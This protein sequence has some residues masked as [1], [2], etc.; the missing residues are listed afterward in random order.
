MSIQDLSKFEEL[1]A[2]GRL[3]SPKGVAVAILRLAQREDVT[4][5]DLARLVKTDPA[6]AGRLI[7][8]ANSVNVAARRPVVAVN[9]AIMLLGIPAVTQ[10]AL[11][12]SLV[13]SYRTGACQGFDYDGFWSRSLFT[14]IAMQALTARTGTAAPE[15][16][17][18]CGLLSRIG[19]LALATLYPDDYS[20]VLKNAEAASSLDLTE[21]EQHAFAL[22]HR[23]LTAAQLYDWGIPKALVEPVVHHETPDDGEFAEGSR[24]QILTGSLHL[25]A[26]LA[27]MCTAETGVRAAMLMGLRQACERIGIDTDTLHEIADKA[28][29]DWQEWGELLSVPTQKLPPFA[30]IAAGPDRSGASAAVTADS[31]ALEH[32]WLRVLVVDD[33][34]AVL[35]FLQR[36]LQAEGYEVHVA[37]NGRDALELALDVHPQIVIADS[38]MP[39]MDGIALTRALRQSR[40][41]RSMYILVLTGAED[42]AK[43]VEA[44][45]A[46]ADDFVAKPPRP[47]VLEARL[48]AGRRVIQLRRE[49]EEDREEIR[50]VATELAASNRRLRHAAMLDPLTEFPNRRYAIERLDQEWAHASRSSRPLACMVIDVDSFKHVNDSYGHEAGDAVL[51]KTA[52]VLKRSAR[53]HD[54]ICRIGGDE[55]LVICPDTEST[56][57]L[58]AGERLC[59]AVAATSVEYSSHRFNGSVSVGIAARDPDMPDPRAMMR[60]ADQAMYQA[61]HAGRN[62]ARVYRQLDTSPGLHGS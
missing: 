27:E 54:V 31:A 56:A 49:L 21:L 38:V 62:R 50:D 48:R 10:L 5:S 42:E 2:S 57:A 30:Q 61:K 9:E 15:E 60:A 58:Q 13:T 6:F 25:A 29:A 3:P 53:A 45:D 46:G 39:E 43:L 59:R 11:G 22:D 12:F 24:A 20:K 26:A 17:F 19:N 55:F 16:T 47:R 33:D 35:L 36:L 41:G 32:A 4:G 23:E 34:A 18:T 8:A 1:K 28:V 51:R 37:S 40:F 44:L 14:A 52:E 7:K